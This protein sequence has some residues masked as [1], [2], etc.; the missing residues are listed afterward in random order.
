MFGM[1]LHF[2]LKDLLS[3]KAIAIPGPSRKFWWRR[4]WEWPWQSCQAGP[5]A[6]VRSFVIM[7]EREI[8]LGMLDHTFGPEA[9]ATTPSP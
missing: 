9:G 1:G 5:Q 7:G 2:S 8:A 4:F 6:R 3:V